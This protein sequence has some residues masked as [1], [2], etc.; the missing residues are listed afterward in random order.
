MSDNKIKMYIVENP[1]PNRAPDE[2]IWGVEE[3]GVMLIKV[4]GGMSASAC[5]E[6]V[7]AHRSGKKISLSNLRTYMR[8]KQ[9][10]EKYFI[11]G[12]YREFNGLD[13]FDTT[14]DAK[15]FIERRSKEIQANIKYQINN[16]MEPLRYVE[17][18]LG[19]MTNE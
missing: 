10:V 6:F 13:Y 12:E 5:I 18:R 8:P 19:C 3:D 15:A 4:A 1:N 14:E 2:W 7:E 17:Y 16:K 11:S 9:I